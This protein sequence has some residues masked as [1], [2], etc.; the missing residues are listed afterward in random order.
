MG[1]LIAQMQMSVDGRVSA[2]DPSLSWQ[3]W[4]WDENW[5]WD[6]DLKLVFNAIFASIGAI[7]LSRPM[8]EEGYLDHWT[9]TARRFEHDP[10][11]DFARRIV[12][13]PKIVLTDKLSV[14]RWERTTIARGGIPSAI[15]R[16][17]SES[18]DD[19]ITFGGTGFVSTLIA[20]GVVDELQLFINPVAVG[21][22]GSIFADRDSIALRL[23]QSDSFSCGMVVNR[24]ALG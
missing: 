11:Y 1:K 24:Y 7:L 4:E 13:V 19:I 6:V 14:S 5:D 17:K 21:N 10:S 3:L 8:I 12:E 15:E 22:G 18:T 23:L 2:S 20:S 16:L 9:G